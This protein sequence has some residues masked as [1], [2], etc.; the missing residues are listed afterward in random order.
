MHEL[1][2]VFHMID[3]LKAVAADNDVQDISKVVVEL[4]EVST[5]I[6]SYLQ[7]CWKWVAVKHDFLKNCELGIEIIPAVTYCEACGKEYGTVEFGRAC[8]CCGSG[9]TYL[10]RGNEFLIKEIEVP[11]V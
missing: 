2:V 4:G 6:P 10:I 3:E 8:P 11:E 7:D 1:G 9:R 5:V